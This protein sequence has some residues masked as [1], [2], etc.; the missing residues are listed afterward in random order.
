MYQSPR[1]EGVVI[2]TMLCYFEGIL[3]MLFGGLLLLFL[4]PILKPLTLL[5]LL[6]GAD[7]IVYLAYACLTLLFVI[8]ALF[9]VL[10]WGL[11]NLKNWARRMSKLLAMIGLLAFP[12]GTAVGLVIIHYLRKPEVRAAFR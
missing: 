7:G 1:P 5:L 6:V 11:W 10:G 4:A 9:V 2:L 8:G 3:I 12:A